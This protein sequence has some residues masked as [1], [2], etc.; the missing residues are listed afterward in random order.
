MGDA[1][2][3]ARDVTAPARRARV[4]IQR[5]QVPSVAAADQEESP[6][7]DR[8]RGGV[9][10]RF[11]RID[12][13]PQ[14]LAVVRIDRGGQ[15]TGPDTEQRLSRVRAL[16]LPVRSGAR[17]AQVEF[18]R[19]EGALGDGRG[20]PRRCGVGR[21]PAQTG[22]GEHAGG[23]RGGD[24]HGSRRQPPTP[25]GPSP[26]GHVGRI[27]GTFRTP[28]HSRPDRE[29]RLRRLPVA[30][31]LFGDERPG[32]VRRRDRTQC[33]H[34]LVRGGPVLRLLGE[35][36]PDQLGQFIGHARQVGLVVDHLI[37]DQ[38]RTVRIEGAA[39]GGGVH[40][41]RAEREHVGGRAHVPWLAELFR[42][43]ERRSADQFAGL[44][45]QFTVRGAGDAEVDD[46]RTVVRQQDV[47]GL[48]VAVDDPGPVDVPQCLGESGHQMTQPRGGHRAVPLHV[49]G[50]RRPG[51]EQRCHPRAFGLGIGVHDRCGEGTADPPGG[52]DL[53]TEPPPE[54]GV[55]GELGVYDLDGQPQPGGG[56]RQMHDSHATGAE[57]GLQQVLAG[58]AWLFRFR[59]R[60]GAALWRHHSPPWVRPRARRAEPS[61]FFVRNPGGLLA[62]ARV[63]HLA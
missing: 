41:Q 43:H 19:P 48:E 63:L 37:R 36:A 59:F 8:S 27:L 33:R 61:R 7:Q 16:R 44:R 10:T 4:G 47:A 28:G 57:S 15:D 34:E 14:H 58:I 39:P 51:N 35:T 23:R 13:G 17:G 21:V 20:R 1:A 42:R 40:D 18:P 31:A 5:G 24:G 45:P 46:F 29:G 62:S 12:P 49:L 55:L 38:I 56:A 26:P 53:L 50:E 22:D 32:V 60:T 3:V 11:P 54:L 9:G 6:G 25:P 52:R 2:R 30:E